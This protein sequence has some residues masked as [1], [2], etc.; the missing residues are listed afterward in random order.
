MTTPHREGCLSRPNYSM[1]IVDTNPGKQFALGM[2]SLLICPYCQ[3]FVAGISASLPFD[4]TPIDWSY[5][6]SNMQLD[7]NIGLH[8]GNLMEVE[9]DDS[10]ADCICCGADLYPYLIYPFNWETECVLM[11]PI[12]RM[13]TKE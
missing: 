10:W 13:F 12:P 1:A 9:E 8:F 4:P 6:L 11:V 3:E 5:C 7:L 2:G